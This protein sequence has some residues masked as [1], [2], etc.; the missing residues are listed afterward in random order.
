MSGVM[1]ASSLLLRGRD[2]FVAAEPTGDAGYRNAHRYRAGDAQRPGRYQRGGRRR[3]R[4]QA[5]RHGGLM[6]LLELDRARRRIRRIADLDY[7]IINRNVGEL[8]AILVALAVFL[9]IMGVVVGA[10]RRRYRVRR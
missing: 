7:P 1:R 10:A 8:A 9:D 5:A 3:G 2:G 4:Q 6:A